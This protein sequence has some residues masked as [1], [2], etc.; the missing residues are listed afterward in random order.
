M[1]VTVS[2]Y[3][4]HVDDAVLDD[5]RD[6][7]RRARF[8]D[9][10]EGAG[11]DYGADL[12]AL[13]ELCR[14]WAED[15]DWRAQEAALNRFEHVRADVDGHGVHLV[16]AR[17]EDPDAIPLVLLH[18]WPSTF[19]QMLPI[20]PL[21]TSGSPAFHCVVPSL[22]GYGFSD[23]PA[24][25]GM[26]VARMA[27][28][29]ARAVTEGLGYERFG[30]RAADVGHGMAVS[31]ALA[32]S[33]AVIGTHLSGVIPWLEE[34]PSDL[35]PAEQ[36][37]VARGRQWNRDEAAYARVNFTKPQTHAAALNDSPAGLAALFAEKFRVW[38]DPA[39]ALARDDLLTHMTIY[40]ATETIGSAMRAYYESA[41]APEFA[42]FAAPVAYAILPHDILSPV[43]REWLERQGPVARFT[44]LPRGGHF[45]EQEVPELLAEDLRAFFAEVV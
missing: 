13:R 29:V 36:D 15:Y 25:P 35:T 34:V 42:P 40:W 44:E 1:A 11:W 18:G 5:L 43:P 27:E 2:P 9:A 10:V 45:G 8:P 41:R 12:D 26:S 3:E 39:T 21:L 33:P 38:C 23:R 28:V 17:S 30:V 24:R 37:F 32:G 6:R 7:L 16:H 4:I 22:P 20:L 14:A 19:A 31:P